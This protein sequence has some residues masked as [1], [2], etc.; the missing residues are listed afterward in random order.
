MGNSLYKYEIIM[1]NLLRG[2]T[3]QHSSFAKRDIEVKKFISLLKMWFISRNWQ[4]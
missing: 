2:V 4:M 3:I 1:E